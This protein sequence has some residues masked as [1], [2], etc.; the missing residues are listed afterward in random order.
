MP[1]KKKSMKARKQEQTERNVLLRNIYLAK[2]ELECATQN[3]SYA[4]DPTLIDM[5]SYQIKACQAKYHYL[6]MQAK[7]TGLTQAGQLLAYTVTG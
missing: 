4:T 7:E 5:Y 6:M 2:Y 3:F 1:E